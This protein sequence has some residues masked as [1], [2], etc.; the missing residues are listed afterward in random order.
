MILGPGLPMLFFLPDFILSVVSDPAVLGRDFNELCDFDLGR[1]ETSS[2]GGITR[3]WPLLVNDI[4]PGGMF[5]LS[6][7]GLRIS[8]ALRSRLSV[9]G[10]IG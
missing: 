10:V 6:V 5:S 7:D 8:E 9:F 1:F 3:H 2:S 4:A